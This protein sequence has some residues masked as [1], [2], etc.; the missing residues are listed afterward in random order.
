M[1][2]III[3]KALMDKIIRL[4]IFKNKCLAIYRKCSSKMIK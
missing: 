3:I 4:L 1:K 2:L